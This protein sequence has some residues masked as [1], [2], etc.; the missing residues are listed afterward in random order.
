MIKIRLNSI[1]RKVLRIIIPE[2]IWPK[3]TYL[4]GVP[5]QVRNRK[6][7]FGSKRILTNGSYEEAERDLL[8]IIDITGFNVI[9]MGSSIGILTQILAYRVGKSGIIIGIEADLEI[10]SQTKADLHGL[11]NIHILHGYAFPVFKIEQQ[12]NIV[13]FNK[14]LGSLGGIVTFELVSIQTQASKENEKIYDIERIIKETQIKPDMLVIDIEGSEQMILSCKS[15]FPKS[16]KYIL[17]E[18]HPGIYS[19]QISNEIVENLQSS[20]FYVV[21]KID[22]SYLFHRDN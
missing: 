18:L 14:A 10:A 15:L 21:M 16:I 13:D 7:S 11:S 22:N 12:I 6:Y 9:E 5:I 19:Q 3:I 1:R 17:M 20:G 8:K 2:F 4:D